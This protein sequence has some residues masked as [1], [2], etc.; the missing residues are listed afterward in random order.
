MGS[1]WLLQLVHSVC[2]SVW[3]NWWY[4]ILAELVPQQVEIDVST[5][6]EVAGIGCSCTQT[7]LD[8]LIGE[9]W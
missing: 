7:H 9:N 3:S 8:E 5:W 1:N 2:Q 4:S 6:L